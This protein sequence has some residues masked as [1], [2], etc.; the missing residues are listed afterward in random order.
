MPGISSIPRTVTESFT[1]IIS[2]ST[3]IRRKV[4]ELKSTW[5]YSGSLS[6]GPREV[7]VE[8]PRK[9]L[10]SNP[11]MAVQPRSGEVGWGEVC[12]RADGKHHS[13]NDF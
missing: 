3:K 12:S 5:N 2:R 8:L 9:Q 11:Q 4:I 6:S 1:D 7:K 10:K 13:V